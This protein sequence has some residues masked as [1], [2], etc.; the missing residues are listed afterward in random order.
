MA[1]DR[2]VFRLSSVFGR[3]ALL[4][5]LAACATHPLGMS[6]EE[7]DRLTP[8]QRLEA[9]RQDERN[10]LE[11]RRLRLEE[12]RQREQAQE[13]RDVAEGMILSFRPERAYCMG[14]DKCGRDSFDELILSLQRMAA[15]DRVLFFADDNI[16]T[17]HDGL[18]SVY[19]DDVLVARDIDVKRNGKWHQVLVGRPARN[20]T[21]RAQGDD[22]VS[23]YQVKVYGSWLQDGADYL[24]V[25]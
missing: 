9:R 12:E 7:W 4:L 6:D 10:E 20:I 24:I 18:V 22:E 11:R 5:L 14:G 23:V 19:A 15:V 21:L 13:Q 8:E 1:S 3:F 2:F 16:G 25:R 17:K